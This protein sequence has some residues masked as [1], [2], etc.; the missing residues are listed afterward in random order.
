MIDELKKML[1]RESAAEPDYSELLRKGAM[2]ID[3]R[4][5]AEYA[6][7]HIRGSIN[8]PVDRLSASLHK[9]KDKKCPVIACCASGVRSAKARS[10]LLSHG[11]ENV[12]NGGG[13]HSLQQKI[14]GR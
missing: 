7:G 1:G 10:I 11:Y 8:I 4:S 2:L 9:L 5:E 13:W 12:Y 6:G 3:V 14:T